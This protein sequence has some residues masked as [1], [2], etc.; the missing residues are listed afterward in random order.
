MIIAVL[1]L[2]TGCSLIPGATMNKRAELYSR[3]SL[4]QAVMHYDDIL[5]QLR[6]R[7]SAETGPFAWT[8]DGERS[9][10]GCGEDFPNM[11]GNTRSTPR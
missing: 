10:A 6:D 3:P 4:E 2:T 9:G 8:T 11:G 7:L 1:A 5:T